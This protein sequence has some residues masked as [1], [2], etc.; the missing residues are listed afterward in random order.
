MWLGPEYRSF[1]TNLTNQKST[2]GNHLYY[3]G[4]KASYRL[5]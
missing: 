3:G 1:M 4:L 2:N 5:R